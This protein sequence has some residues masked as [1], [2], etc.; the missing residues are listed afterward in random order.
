MF[1]R[2]FSALAAVVLTCGVVAIASPA[3]AQD[4]DSRSVTVQVEDIDFSKRGAK[5]MLDRRLKLAARQVCADP[6]LA[7]V[8][9]R[10][11]TLECEQQAIEAAQQGLPLALSNEPGSVRL[12]GLAR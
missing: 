9:A 11:E 8:S 7:G 10:A 2:S 12:A 6:S 5:A 4:G 1:I 3:H